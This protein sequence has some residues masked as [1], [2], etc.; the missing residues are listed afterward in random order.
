VGEAYGKAVHQQ[1]GQLLEDYKGTALSDRIYADL[2]SEQKDWAKA[3]GHLRRAV[4]RDPQ[5]LDARLELA[6]VFVAQ[7]RFADA[8]DQLDLRSRS[9]RIRRRRWLAAARCF[10]SCSSPRMAFCVLRRL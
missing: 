5:S 6:G 9:L 2:Y 8:K 7:A 4:Q 1:T 3:E 10:S